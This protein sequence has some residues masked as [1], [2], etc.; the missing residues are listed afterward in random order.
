MKLDRSREKIFVALVAVFGFMLLARFAR[1][2]TSPHQPS[3]VPVPA[4][5]R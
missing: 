2:G 1:L 3:L 5:G 4:P